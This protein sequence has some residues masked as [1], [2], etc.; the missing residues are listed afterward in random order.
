MA[1]GQ[2]RGPSWKT[3][4]PLHCPI[5]WTSL[6]LANWVSVM[7][8]TR[9]LRGR[10]SKAHHPSVS[11]VRRPTSRKPREVGHPAFVP[12][13]RPLLFLATVVAEVFLA[14]TLSPD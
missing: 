11:A 3:G 14:W 13:L 8:I 9:C 10:K 7:A 5:H 2:L 12:A 6:H 4:T 1:L